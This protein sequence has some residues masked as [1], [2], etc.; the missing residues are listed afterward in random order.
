MGVAC[1][2]DYTVS[3]NPPGVYRYWTM[4]EAGEVN[5]V[6]KYA[7]DILLPWINHLDFG[8]SPGLF[9]NALHVYY[10][11]PVGALGAAGL[12]SSLSPN[13]N[14]WPQA[15][16]NDNGFSV[17]GW[18]YVNAITAK[19]TYVVLNVG[20]PA[21]L[22]FVVQM[23]L[24]TSSFFFYLDALG[25]S[26]NIPLAAPTLG[27]WIFFHLFFDKTT[28]KAGLSFNNGAE[29]Q[30]GAALVC[31]P[32]TRYY[33]SIQTSFSLPT[34]A[35]DALWDEVVVSING[36]LRPS[37]LAYLYNG[38]VGRTWPLTL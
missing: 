12:L 8:S 25:S 16:G 21:D 4:E 9:N 29:V 27:T 30:Y 13:R 26:G 6:D 11:N 20:T 34:T 2:K 1:S 23:G 15:G 5:R 35:S 18:V 32:T 22:L 24:G 14:T 36:K 33:L 38:G 19:Y 28:G 17:A 7:G 3:V 10:L 31:G 37:Q